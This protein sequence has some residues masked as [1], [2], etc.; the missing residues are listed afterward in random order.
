MLT[1]PAH[2]E[3]GDQGLHLCPEAQIP[4]DPSQKCCSLLLS[5]LPLK[6]DVQDPHY[7]SRTLLAWPASHHCGGPLPT[8]SPRPTHSPVP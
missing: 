3:T 1:L 5:S 2:P 8:T 7:P 6:P 4:S